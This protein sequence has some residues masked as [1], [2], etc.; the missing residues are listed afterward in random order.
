MNNVYLVRSKEEGTLGIFSSL[1]KVRLYLASQFGTGNINITPS[2]SG[3]MT[4]LPLTTP[5][6]SKEFKTGFIAFLEAKNCLDDREE[7][8]VIKYEVNSEL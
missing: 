6:L 3:F 4:S 8:E 1:Q 2:I 5:L 7:L